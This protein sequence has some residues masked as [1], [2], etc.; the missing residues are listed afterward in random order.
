MKLKKH[1]DPTKK[2]NKEGLVPP[3]KI[4][5]NLKDQ[6][7]A[8]HEKAVKLAKV[9]MPKRTFGADQETEMDQDWDEEAATAATAETNVCQGAYF[10]FYQTAATRFR[11]TLMWAVA[12]AMKT[13]TKQVWVSQGNRP[14]LQVKEGGKVTKTLTFVQT[15]K[16]YKEKIT[17]KTLEEVKKAASK[18][19]AGKLEQ[20]FIVIK[21]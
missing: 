2:D 10:T 17:P 1:V 7:V 21:D 6:A 14:T 15:M 19:F 20:T 4:C 13:K 3:F 9:G 18:L 12:D 8:F 16:E 11:V 5:F